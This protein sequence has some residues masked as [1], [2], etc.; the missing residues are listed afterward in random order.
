MVKPNTS[1]NRR[2]AMIRLLLAVLILLLLNVVAGLYYYRLDLTSEKRYSISTPTKNMVRDLKDEVTV[3]VYL[4]GDLNAGFTRL[5]ESTRNLLKEFRAYGGINIEYEFID[6][7]AIQNLDERKAFITD[8]IQK[9]LAPTNLTTK[10][11]TGSNQQLIFPGAIITYLGREMPV[12]LL[13]NQIG[14]SPQEILNNS[15]VQLEY[16]FANAIKKLM[17]NRPPRIAFIHGHNELPEIETADL[18]ETLQKLQY[19]IK[20]INLSREY[21]IQGSFDAIVI[22]KP[23]AAFDEKDKYK[24]DQYIM[25][26]GKT[27][28]LVDGT[29]AALDSLKGNPT[30]QFV[31]ANELNLSDML[32]KYGVRINSDLVQDISLCNPIPLVVGQMGSAPQTELFPW[33]YFPLLQSDNN[34]AIIKNIDPVESFFPS[35]IDTVRNPGIKKTI[36]LHSSDNAKAQLAPTRVHFGILQSKPNPAYFNQARIPVAVLLEGPFE[37]VFKNRLAP[38]FL[39]ASD[40]IKNLKFVDNSTPNKMIIISNGDVIRNQL[41]SDSSWY[42]LGYYMFTK[43]QFANK[44]FILNCLEYLIDNTGIL[45]TRNKEVKLRLLDKVKVE[46]EKLKWQIINIVVPISIIIIVGLIFN[47]YRKRKYAR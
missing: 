39:A 25:H 33:Y 1:L 17:A 6:P 14:Y 15:E 43:Q 29:D 23:R 22:A 3:K 4:G 19:E 2:D 27:L 37:S 32:F 41:R 47:Y 42:P 44:D 45:E 46:N 30:G 20:D 11:K 24:I 38:E 8:L 18:R 16:K 34:H 12:Q 35:S 7:M 5:K 26:G 13:E 28:W 21:Y 36:L 31:V 9:G 10:S 40:T